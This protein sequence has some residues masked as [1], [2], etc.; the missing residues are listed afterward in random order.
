MLRTELASLLN[1]GFKARDVIKLLNKSE[2]AKLIKE[3][4]HQLLQHFHNEKQFNI[5]L[6]QA[7]KLGFYMATGKAKPKLVKSARVLLLV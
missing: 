4:E 3:Y 6:H 7:Y 1:H 2:R 5:M